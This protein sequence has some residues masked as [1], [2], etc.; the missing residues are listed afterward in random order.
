M[1]GPHGPKY[2][3][4]PAPGPLH[5]RFCVTRGERAASLSWASVGFCPSHLRPALGRL[6]Q[7]ELLTID[8]EKGPV[9]K[10]APA[11]QALWR[12]LENED[13]ILHPF[14]DKRRIPLAVVLPP[15]ARGPAQSSLKLKSIESVMPSNHLI[16]CCLLLLLP[17]IPPSIRV[18]HA[19]II[20][21]AARSSPQP[22]DLCL[23]SPAISAYSAVR[24]AP[25]HICVLDILH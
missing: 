16:L 25:A 5:L 12:P 23:L 9:G 14:S 6:C 13:I 10:T 24:C 2:P 15:P 11:T 18:S 20:Y 1:L 17:P 8:L 4:F 22:L 19:I 21:S 7:E 3:W